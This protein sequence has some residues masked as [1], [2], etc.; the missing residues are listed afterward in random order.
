MIK[1]ADEL[2]DK[3]YFPITIRY[4]E[5]DRVVTLSH[6]DDIENGKSFVVLKCND[7]HNN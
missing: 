6:P 7:E 1:I 5:D 2:H 4:T 3:S